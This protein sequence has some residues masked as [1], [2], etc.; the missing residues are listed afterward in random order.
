M[1]GDSE[2]VPLAR[3]G[4]T[5]VLGGWGGSEASPGFGSAAPGVKTLVI[6][7]SSRHAVTVTPVALGNERL[8]AFW[9]GKG[10]SPVKWTAYDAKGG[11]I[12]SGS[13]EKVIG[14]APKK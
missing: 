9:V 3:L 5:P 2:C 13:M 4:T 6:A 11:K 7:L 10:V 14:S 8:F 1:P 12:G